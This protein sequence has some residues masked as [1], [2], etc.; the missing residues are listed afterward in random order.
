MD[1]QL[2]EEHSLL[3]K[4]VREFAEAEIDPIAP[5]FDESGT[6]PRE[7]VAAMGKLGLLGMQLPPEYNGSGADTLSYAIA[8]E[9]I[10]RVDG[11]HGLIMAAHNSLCSGHIALAGSEEQ[12]RRYIPKLATGEMV[13]AWGLTEPASGS[14]AGAIET[15]A[16]LDGDEWVLNGQKNLITNGPVA[17][18][19]VLMAKTDREKGHRGV[20]AF[21]VD[22][23]T[24]GLEVGEIEDKLG[25]RASATSAIY[26]R[27]CRVPREDLLGKENEG[28]VDALKILDGGRISIAAM[29]LG[30]AQG[31]FDRAVA[32]AKEREQFGQPISQFQA[33]QFMLADMAVDI[34]ASRMLVYRAARAKDSGRKYKLE[35][36]MAKLYASEAAMRVTSKAIQVHGG[37]GYIK[38][39]A[40]ERMYRDA[41]LCTIGEGTS[42]IQRLVI[43]RELLK[44]GL[45]GAA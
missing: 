33:I 39:Y 24:E 7:S 28:Y 1:F 41:K 5:E 10:S 8:V 22:E 31:A 3:R 42:E 35:A 9:E 34:D 19:F 4:S 6:F 21:I 20:S 38:E 37:Y 43:A 13:G 11:G 16:T 17:G 44:G 12:L 18:V 26:L 32:Y 25:V 29:A 45:P 15:T 23:G 30:I 27:D 2:D 14:D 40:V 36:A